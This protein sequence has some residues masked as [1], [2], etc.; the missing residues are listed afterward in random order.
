MNI[1]HNEP[2]AP[3]TSLRVGGLA[4]TLVLTDTYA[5]T[6]EAL[7]KVSDHVW[8]LGYGCNAL[9]SDDGLPGTTIMWRGGNIHVDDTLLV[10]DA[11]AWW[12]DV[13]KTAIEHELWGL[14]LMSEIP[15]SVGA[16]VVGNI[17]AYGQQISD[18]LVWTDV[19][20]TSRHTVER[21]AREAI[22]LRYR[23][24]SLQREPH[25]IVLRAAFQLSRT[26]TKQLTYDTALVIADE[27]GLDHATLPHRRDIIVET[28]RRG[29][30]LYHPGEP[31]TEHTA[32][33]FF[34]N[35]M[36]SPEQAKELAAFDETGKTLERILN[37]SIVHGGN[38]QR[39]SAAHVLL[40]AGFHRGQRWNSV[41]LHP[42]HVL[43][44]ATLD[45]ATAREVYDVTQEI[46]TTV[47]T[48]LGIDLEPEVKFLGTF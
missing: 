40:A 29:G 9:I 18:T 17:A 11:G 45:G 1:L 20:D 21:L 35:P 12:D 3:Y 48:K 26:Q 6:I 34:K 15:S 43:K 23:E 47:K 24:S 13:V 22:D 28:R 8:F 19:Y 27:L 42:S 2:L 25:R 39:A 41:E 31:A 5:E 7:Q 44:L 10:A 46:V 38:A 16:A 14:E 32:G 33:S 4:E 30:S 37:Q 36:V